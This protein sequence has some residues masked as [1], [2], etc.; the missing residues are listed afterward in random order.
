[1]AHNI[2]HIS[3]VLGMHRSGTSA[4]TRA[5]HAVGFEL[6]RTIMSPVAGDNAQGFYESTAIM[7]LNDRILESAGQNWYSL[8]S[9]PDVWF[10]SADAKI[11]LP[12]IKDTVLAEYPNTKKIVIKDPRINKLLPL[13]LGALE[14]IQS[15]ISI[16]VACR[17][18]LEVA[19]SLRKRNSIDIEHGVLLWLEHNREI[20]RYTRG[21]QRLYVGFDNLLSHTESQLNRLLSALSVD[22]NEAAIKKS[23]EELTESLQGNLKN[24]NVD[25][26]EL[27]KFELRDISLAWQFLQFQC[28]ADLSLLDRNSRI[29]SIDAPL[30][31][32]YEKPLDRLHATWANFRTTRFN[33]RLLSGLLS[34]ANTEIEN[35]KAQTDKTNTSHIEENHALEKKISGLAQELDHAKEQHL[36]LNEQLIASSDELSSERKSVSNLTAQLSHLEQHSHDTLEKLITRSELQASAHEKVLQEETQRLEALIVKAQSNVTDLRS[37]LVDQHHRATALDRQLVST[38]SSAA[39]RAGSKVLSLTRRFRGS[40]VGRSLLLV[41]AAVGFRLGQWL[42]IRRNIKF[43]ERSGEFDVEHYLSTYPI[44]AHSRLSPIEHYV[45]NGEAEGRTP[46]ASF[47]PRVFAH[48]QNYDPN[49][50]W[51]IF[52][53]YLQLS[54]AVREDERTI[55]N[56]QYVIASSATQ[57][58]SLNEPLTTKKSHELVVTEETSID[59]RLL[60]FSCSDKPIASVIIPVFNN[61]KDTLACLES[62]TQQSLNDFEVIVVDD[63]STIDMSD[64]GL[65]KGIQLI[66]NRQNLGYLHSA[67]KGASL[68]KGQFIVQLNNDTIVS[69]G[70]LKALLAPLQEDASIGLAGSQMLS[71]DGLLQE[72]GGIIFADGSGYNYGRTDN[73]D[74]DLYNFVRDCDYC[75]GASIALPANVWNSLGG[76]DAFFTPAYYE[77][78]DLAMRVRQMGLRVVY[79]PFSKLIHIEGVSCGSDESDANSMKRFQKIN[80]VKFVERWNQ[81]LTRYGSLDDNREIH[82]HVAKTNRLG[83]IL[84]VDANTPTPD[85]DAGSIDTAQHLSRLKADGWDVTFAGG[86]GYRYEGKYT[87]NLRAIGIRVLCQGHAHT[88][89][90]I[91]SLNIDFDVIT[92]SRAP[93]AITAHP[94]LKKLFP[95]A[96]IVFNTVDLHYLRYERELELIS[97]N[98]SNSKPKNQPVQKKDELAIMRLADAT[99]VVSDMEKQLLE[100]ELDQRDASRVAVIPSPRNVHPPTRTFEERVDVGFLGSYQHPPN[101]DAVD[102][103][104]SNIWPRFSARMPGVRFI[105]AGSS[106]PEKFLKLKSDTIRPIG[107]VE[108]LEG[109]MESVRIMVA[110]LRYGAGIKGKVISSM[111]YGIPQVATRMAAEGMPLTHNVELLIANDDADFVEQMIELY[112][113][114]TLWNR[115]STE[116]MNCVDNTFSSA[117]VETKLSAVFNALAGTR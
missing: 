100:T 62:L 25:A 45:C 63:G 115:L 49:S 70:W 48:S 16:V 95:Q 87:D 37:Q 93:V 112:T 59:P 35:V 41:K 111:C 1:M 64:L 17:H 97:S 103:F 12:E 78:T 89:A 5:M 27:S 94:V 9:I 18:P 43:L 39:F 4:L 107:F 47:N 19:E 14:Q 20:A 53:Q 65:V 24:F 77:D 83:R 57:E 72:A 106:I 104:L 102:H 36:I 30:I 38:R 34:D 33:A 84:W 58:S 7:E 117:V 26:S 75:S 42:R 56:P 54:E 108:D 6:P 81:E 61:T 79:T 13:W 10:D 74:N 86:D 88:L 73:P 60:Q 66:K 23:Y 71:K 11:W 2:S 113:N 91:E 32:T 21:L 44:L 22:L 96:K 50:S 99:L 101:I 82:N 109:L 114:E 51:G 85:Q 90:A 31:G 3:I 105:I 69:H 46:S 40:V 76:Y 8:G 15:K 80:R 29:P 28:N 92:L 55:E 68:A 116:G 67:N 98:N 110:P 52:A